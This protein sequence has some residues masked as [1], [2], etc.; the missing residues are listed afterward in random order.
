MTEQFVRVN[1]TCY[2]KLRKI[3]IVEL[4]PE[5]DSITIKGNDISLGDEYYAEV[6]ELLGIKL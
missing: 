5:S 1:K 6:C 4:T 2:V 3:D